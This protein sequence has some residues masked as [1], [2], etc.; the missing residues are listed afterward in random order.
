MRMIKAVPVDVE[1]KPELSIFA[2][3]AFLRAVGDEYGWI[4]G[5]D[6]TGVRCCLLPF[7]IVQ[8]LGMRM[9]RFRVETVPLA[10]KFSVEE[11]RSFLDNAMEYLRSVGG[12]V[13]IPAT[14]NT[15]FRTYPIGAVAAP[16]GSYVIDLRQPEETI[17]RN[18]GARTRQYIKAAPKEGVSVR[19]GPEHAE[20]AYRLITDTLRRSG[21]PFMSRKS[22]TTYLDGLGEYGRVMIAE[23]HGRMQSCAVYAYSRHSAYYVYAGNDV[24]YH[25]G[26]GKLMHWEAILEFRQLGVQW[27]DFVGARIAPR[28]GSKQDALGSFKRRFGGELREGYMWKYAIRPFKSFPYTIG[29][30]LL[31]GGDIVDHERHKL[32]SISSSRTDVSNGHR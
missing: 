16:Y 5:I 22:F 18:I 17:W 14:T 28:P 27:Y 32:K 1:W 9:V 29:V 31:R 3:P 2:S 25:H 24:P 13:V 19:T 21:L 26:A 4:G 8:R 23:H 30:R 12:D 11:E 10:D 20:A 6:E 7:T 15:I